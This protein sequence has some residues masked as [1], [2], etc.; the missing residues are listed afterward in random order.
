[1]II[2]SPMRVEYGFVKRWTK[3]ACA[4]S[5]TTTQ[6]HSLHFRQLSGPQVIYISLQIDYRR[7]V[8]CG[9]SKNFQAQTESSRVQCDG[10]F[11]T[12][13]DKGIKEMQ[14]AANEE[15]IKKSLLDLNIP[16]LPW[17]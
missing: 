13:L 3:R 15:Q 12:G 5:F 7:L 1:M 2:W 9:F 17:S 8:C 4:G 11:H 10:E 16:T 14:I 6:E